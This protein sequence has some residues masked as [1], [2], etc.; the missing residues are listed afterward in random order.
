M[1]S[2]FSGAFSK[3]LHFTAARRKVFPLAGWWHTLVSVPQHAIR[4]K[5][6]QP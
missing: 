2:L 1:V 5:E 3:A 4:M 6:S